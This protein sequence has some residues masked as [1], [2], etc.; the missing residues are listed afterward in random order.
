MNDAQIIA[1]AIA[2]A[3][4][5]YQRRWLHLSYQHPFLA[6]L[7]ARQIRKDTSYSCLCVSQALSTPHKEWQAFSCTEGKAQEFLEDCRR[8][9]K[10]FCYALDRAGRQAPALIKDSVHTLAFSNGSVIRSRAPTVRSAVGIRGSVF[11]N[12]VGVIPHAKSLYE[13]AYPIVSEARA[14]GRDAQMIVVSNASRKGTWWH[15]FWTGVVA[16]G[17]GAWRGIL[18]TWEGAKRALGWTRHQITQAKRQII[19]SIGGGAFGQ[20]YECKW[21]SPEEGFFPHHLLETRGYDPATALEALDLTRLPQ[22][23]GY[24]IGRRVHPA[25]WGR[26]LLKPQGHDEIGYLLPTEV[27]YQMPYPA[28]RSFL[29]DLIDQRRTR[30]V[31]VDSTGTGDTQCEEVQREFQGS[32]TLVKGVSFAGN[33]ATHLFEALKDHMEGGRFWFDRGDLDLRIELEGIEVHTNNT[34]QEKVHIPEDSFSDGGQR[35]VRHGD[36]AV[37]AALSACGLSTGQRRQPTTALADR[38]PTM[39]RPSWD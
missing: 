31:Y 11:L 4:A 22:T 30:A 28:Q 24:D 2:A 20:W 38:Q 16:K 23:I 8:W 19:E 6:H 3:S 15:G 14:A 33:G 29:A 32:G 39:H 34:G 17:K 1:Q 26:L 35:L 10:L 27:K 25:A 5:G 37:S 21:R 18:T 36:R 7:G 12:E 13:A 9:Y